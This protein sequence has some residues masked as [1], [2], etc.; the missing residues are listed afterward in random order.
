MDDKLEFVSYNGAYPN[1]CSG[2]LVL[3]LNGDEIIFPDDCLSSGGSVSFTE[4]WDEIVSQG[5]WSISRFP[6]GFPEELKKEAEK[7]VNDNIPMGCCG[8]CV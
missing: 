2:Q 8:G 6:Q 7:I 5:N 4:D 3:K 1:L